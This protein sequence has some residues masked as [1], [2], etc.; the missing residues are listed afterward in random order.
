[1]RFSIYWSTQKKLKFLLRKN[2]EDIIWTL[3]QYKDLILVHYKMIP[4]FAME[5]KLK[6][7]L[8]EEIQN[9]QSSKIHRFLKQIFLK[10]QTNL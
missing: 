10:V 6:K 5:T 3:N 1:M 4:S 7:K 8:T 9:S 2:Q